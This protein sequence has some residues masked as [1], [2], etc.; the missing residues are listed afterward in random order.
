MKISREVKTGLLVVLGIVLFVFGYN[1][2]KGRNLLEAEDLYYTD[3]DYN[4]LTK[5][6][7]VT[8][9]GNTV[10]KVQDIS[11]DYETG[12]THIAF[13]VNPN[14]RFSKNSTIRMYE[15]GLMGGN[16][17]AILVSEEGEQAKPGDKL[18]SEVEMGLVTSLSKNFSGLSMD[19]NS[20]L[21]SA[22]SLIV[23]LNKVVNDQSEQGLRHTVAQL[24]ETLKA[25]EATSLHINGYLVD[26]KQTIE[27]TLSNFKSSSE[28]LSV[29]MADLKE[30]DMGA[31]IASLN[32]TLES[33]QS[34]L[35]SVDQGEGTLGKLLKDEGLYNN[36]EGATKEMEEL[37][38]DIKLHP[39]RYFRILSKKEI[40]YTNEETN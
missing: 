23:S 39:K 28:D 21:E 18:K 25:F 7:I 34:V 29:M 1:Y 35:A 19:L 6:S 36:I 2:L 12:K 30:A 5:S 3:F 16:G 15:T 8:V 31:T 40:P 20:A 14:L 37:L 24:N 26:N 38:R 9:K 33:L 32:K 4:A 17:L 13:T 22:D 11:Y 27:A 10:G